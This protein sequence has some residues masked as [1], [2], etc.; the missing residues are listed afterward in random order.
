MAVADLARRCLALHGVDRPSMSFLADELRHIT[1]SLEDLDDELDVDDNSPL[2]PRRKA[3]LSKHHEAGAVLRQDADFFVQS[4]AS[5][6]MSVNA[7][8]LGMPALPR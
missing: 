1:R 5:S 3:K 2:L 8:H 4:S 6:N 7:L